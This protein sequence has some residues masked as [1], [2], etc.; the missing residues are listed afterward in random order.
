MFDP[1]ATLV[2]LGQK[3]YETRSWSTSYRGPLAIHV[4]K[5][6]TGEMA[7]LCHTEPFRSAL[8]ELEDWPQLGCIIGTVELEGCWLLDEYTGPE[9]LPEVS[10]KERAFGDWSPGRWIWPLSNPRRLAMPIPYRGHQS[11]W[12]VPPEVEELL[13]ATE[14]NAHV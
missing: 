14:V 11:L 8:I 2:V 9:F 7:D 6:F 10:D 13:A 12:N 5:S 1:W 4:R 3:V